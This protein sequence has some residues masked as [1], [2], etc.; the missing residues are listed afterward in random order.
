MRWDG[1]ITLGNL[2]VAVTMVAGIVIAMIGL[3]SKYDKAIL[4]LT[5]AVS[6]LETTFA[7]IEGTLSVQSAKIM[8]AEIAIEVTRALREEHHKLMLEEKSL[9]NGV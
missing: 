2:L 4:L 8:A 1:T 3:I 7:A 6:R 9:H 5:S